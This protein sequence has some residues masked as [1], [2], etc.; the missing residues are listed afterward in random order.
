MSTIQRYALI[1][2]SNNNILNIVL[3]DSTIEPPSPESGEIYVKC[4]DTVGTNWTYANGNFTAPSQIPSTASDTSI[5]ISTLLTADGWTYENGKFTA[6]P[7]IIPNH[8]E[9]IKAQIVTIQAQIATIQAQITA[10]NNK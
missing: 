10:I 6:P 7:A 9:Q 2:P 5:S 4:G 1:N 8:I 3:F